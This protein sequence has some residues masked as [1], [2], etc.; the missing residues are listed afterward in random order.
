MTGTTNTLLWA[1]EWDIESQALEQIRKVSQLA[2]VKY[3][4]VMPDVHM[5][6]GAS[7]GTVIGMERA[8][9]PSAVGVDIGCG[10][11]A[12]STGIHV[13]NINPDI[14]HKLRL[15]VEGAVPVGFNL[16]EHSVDIRKRFNM[17][18]EYVTVWHRFEKLYA[19]VAHLRGKAEKQLGTLGGGNHFIELCEDET[20]ELWMTLHSGSRNIGKEI[21]E[22]HI[23]QAKA[24]PPNK[25]LGD[26]AFFRRGTDAYL[27]YLSDLHW[28]QNYALVNRAVMMALFKEVFKGFFPDANFGYEISC[29][30][31]YVQ[32]EVIDGD[33]VIVTRKGAISAH[34]GVLGV[35]PGNMADGSY[36]VRGLGSELSLFSAAHGAGRTMSR[37][38]A[39][40]TFTLDDLIEQTDGIEARKDKG[41]IDEIPGA[42]KDFWQVMEAQEDL[43]ETVTH[44]QTLMCVKG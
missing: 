7:I 38:R 30:H 16:H 20:G 41:I 25:G 40:S 4:R 14:L 24:L 9:A 8:I 19:D 5:G 36:I 27:M 2:P 21:A 32:T 1:N 35:I 18:F 11:S 28:A 23:K 43:V 39:K 26:L 37:G 12:V 42:Y 33:D 34:E 29:H 31:N 13:Q 44:L 22:W 10:V 15:A 17:E 3:V 6:V